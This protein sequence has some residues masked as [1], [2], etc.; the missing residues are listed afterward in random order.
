MVEENNN[1]LSLRGPDLTIWLCKTSVYS[2]I[3]AKS[4]LSVKSASLPVK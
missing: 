1:G 2:L 4:L 3:L